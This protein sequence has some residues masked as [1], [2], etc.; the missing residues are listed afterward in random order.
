M[1]QRSSTPSE[2]LESTSRRGVFLAAAELGAAGLGAALA[3]PAKAAGA[4]GS[5][6]AWETQL[7]HASEV[8]G[9]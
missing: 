3:A 2:A 5:A 6:L 7:L 1:T 9:G 8:T 4:T